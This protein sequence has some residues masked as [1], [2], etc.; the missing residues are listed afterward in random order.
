[1]IKDVT[2]G[3]LLTAL[4]A[5]IGFNVWTSWGIADI[6]QDNAQLRFALGACDARNANIDE[7]RNSDA[8]ALDPDFVIPPRWIM[9]PAGGN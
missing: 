7:D 2:I 8:T 6:R 4:I 1:M 5:A 3:V 9:P